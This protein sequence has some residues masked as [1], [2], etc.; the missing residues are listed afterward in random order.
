LKQEQLH[1]FDFGLKANYENIRG[2]ASMY[3]AHVFDYITYL[4]ISQLAIFNGYKYINTNQ[5]A[6]SGCEAFGEAD[7]TSW[8]TP[9]FTFYYTQGTDLTRNEPLPNIFPMDVRVGFRIHE[10]TKTPTWGTEFTA[11]MVQ[12]QSRVA[13]FLG[14]FSTGGT[15]ELPTGGFTVFDIRGYWAVTKNV[16][17]TAGL[18]N[19]GDRYYR[20]HLD[21]RSGGG[22]FQPGRSLYLGLRVTY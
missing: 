8:L 22:V 19:V 7:L 6:L 10:P 5:A 16:L 4:R 14:D 15:N 20:E 2:G 18:E 12:G 11:R 13:Y 17:A 3:F 9:F 21:Y 1:Q